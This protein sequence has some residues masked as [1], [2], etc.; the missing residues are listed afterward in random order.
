MVRL[1]N[2]KRKKLTPHDFERY[3]V[4][5][6]DDEREFLVPIVEQEPS[7]DDYDTFF[8]K[9]HFRVNHDEF[10]GYLMGGR[11]FYGFGLFI[12][13]KEFVVN[14]N[15]L[16]FVKEIEKEISQILKYQTFSLFPLYYDSSVHLERVGQISGIFNPIRTKK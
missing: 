16:E 2:L 3:P 7:W 9:A 5:T 4:W 14:L 8:I 15:L 12:D 10:D 6:W 1:N 11:T 13:G